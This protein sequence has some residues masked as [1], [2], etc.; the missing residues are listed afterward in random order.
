MTK[1]Y[2]SRWATSNNLRA[3]IAT[4]KLDGLF[5]SYVCIYVC[6]RLAC[7][8]GSGSGGGGVR[9]QIHPRVMK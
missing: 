9:H 5:R 3:A 2:M 1:R 8:L 7:M 6:V 4:Y